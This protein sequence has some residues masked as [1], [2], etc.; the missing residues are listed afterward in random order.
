MEEP[1]AGK[2]LLCKE[3]L[4]RLENMEG[5]CYIKI[6]FFKKLVC[7]FLKKYLL[8][9]L[10]AVTRVPNCFIIVLKGHKLIYVVQAT[11]AFLC[12]VPIF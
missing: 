2:L 5:C 8:K 12:L 6:S 9:L 3:K 11:A 10:C 7:G 1:Y 4:A